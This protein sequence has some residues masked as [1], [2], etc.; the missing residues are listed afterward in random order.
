M[1]NAQW[2]FVRYAHDICP[3]GVIRFAV[4]GPSAVI[5]VLRGKRI[6]TYRLKG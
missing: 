6:H 1:L 3:S 5:G 2:M 4:I